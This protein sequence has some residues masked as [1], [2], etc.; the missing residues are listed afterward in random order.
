MTDAKI[1]L[2]EVAEAVENIS[3]AYKDVTDKVLDPE[4]ITGSLLDLSL[5][6]I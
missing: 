1:D 5:I 4:A 6:H 3:S 2:T